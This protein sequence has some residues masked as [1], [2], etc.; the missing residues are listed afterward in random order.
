[1]GAAALTPEVSE[2]TDGDVESA[3]RLFGERL[4]FG[5]DL[6]EVVTDG[7]GRLDGESGDAVELAIGLVIGESGVE[8]SDA[9]K[10][11]VK[12]IF[13]LL[14]TGSVELDADERAH[15]GLDGFILMEGGREG[16]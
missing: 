4:T 7:L 2:R 16:E 13:C 5:E 6:E 1:M 15:V 11:G 14:L 9:G 3:S 12:G 8:L 10:S